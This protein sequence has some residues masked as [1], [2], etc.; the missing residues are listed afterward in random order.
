M[1]W[2][3][4][5][6]CALFASSVQAGEIDT[7]KS[8]RDNPQ[9]AIEAC[10]RIL[11]LQPLSPL[12]QKKFAAVYANRC[13]ARMYKGDD[14]E[15]A[16]ADCDE[17]L[18]LDPEYASAFHFRGEVLVKQ[19]QYRA[20]IAEFTQAIERIHLLASFVERGYCYQRLGQNADAL[21]DYAM[22]LQLTPTNLADQQAQEAARLHSEAIS[23]KFTA[24]EPAPNQR[25]SWVSPGL[26][27][28]PQPTPAPA[29][30]TKSIQMRLKQGAY[31]VPVAINGRI[32][33]DFI[34]DTGATSVAITGDVFLT[35]VRTGTMTD[36]DVGE[37]ITSTLADGSSVAGMKLKIRSLQ[38]GAGENAV[39]MQNVDGIVSPPAGDL[40]LG[41]SFFRRF[42]S[43]RIDNAGQK[44]IVEE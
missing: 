34:L 22:A 35:M 12:S 24:V 43:W 25:P 44:L 8:V 20:A 32:W 30:L 19:G 15:A 41:Q 39:I 6:V 2:L 17:A 29:S 21:S 7:C 18:R 31:V 37:K 36:A 13:A 23:K 9:A 33:L 4:T 26:S 38:I 28:G 10:S 3:P 11:L 42:K 40:L 1:R 5:M 16:M 14:F 27:T